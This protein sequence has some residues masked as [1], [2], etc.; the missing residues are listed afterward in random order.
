M[1][2]VKEKAFSRDRFGALWITD[3]CPICEKVVRR[4]SGALHGEYRF[5]CGHSVSIDIYANQGGGII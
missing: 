5:T 3:Y 4:V 2:F 1:G